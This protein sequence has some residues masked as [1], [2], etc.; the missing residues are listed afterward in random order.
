MELTIF[1]QTKLHFKQSALLSF[2]V[3]IPASAGELCFLPAD[4]SRS[5]KELESERE[6]ERKNG[7]KRERKKKRQEKEKE[8]KRYEKEKR[9]GETCLSVTCATFLVSCLR[10]Y[11]KNKMAA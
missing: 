8:K 5:V 4:G 3:W 10:F 2:S 9:M 7:R 11:I 6:K 1:L